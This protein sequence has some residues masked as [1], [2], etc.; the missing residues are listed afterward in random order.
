MCL[1]CARCYGKGCP[2]HRYGLRSLEFGIKHAI[3]GHNLGRVFLTGGTQWMGER[4]DGYRIGCDLYT[5]RI[6]PRGPDIG[7]LAQV[8]VLLELGYR[9]LVRE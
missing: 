6:A 3:F 7:G 1:S 8:K 5:G 2:R 9:C 4:V